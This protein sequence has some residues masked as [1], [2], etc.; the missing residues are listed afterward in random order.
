MQKCNNNKLQNVSGNLSESLDSHV[1]GQFINENVEVSI[2][3]FFCLLMICRALDSQL[4][5]EKRR[6]G[7]KLWQNKNGT[8]H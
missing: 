7:Q 4:S 6:Y 1:H 3:V 8:T 2:F 5:E